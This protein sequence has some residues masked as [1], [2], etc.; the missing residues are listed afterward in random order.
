MRA[1]SQRLAN[2]Q[3]TRLAAWAFGSSVACAFAAV[4]A[5]A[6]MG[7]GYRPEGTVPI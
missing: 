1:F 4:D 5:K 7:L 3:G 6:N 2:L